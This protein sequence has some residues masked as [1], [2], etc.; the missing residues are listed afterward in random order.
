MNKRRSGR[1]SDKC[2]SRGANF[3]AGAVFGR[4]LYDG[5]SQPQVV[6]LGK[7]AT[8]F[9]KACASEAN[10]SR[11]AGDSVLV[12]TERVTSDAES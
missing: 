11:E 12:K 2:G 7:S 8:C 10:R 4:K 1:S 6:D 9:G 5:R 3:T